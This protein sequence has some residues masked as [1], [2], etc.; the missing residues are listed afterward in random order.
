MFCTRATTRA[1]AVLGGV[2]SG[3][4]MTCGQYTLSAYKFADVHRA[5]FAMVLESSMDDV[6]CFAEN[7]MAFIRYARSILMHSVLPIMVFGC[8]GVF[9]SLN[10]YFIILLYESQYL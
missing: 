5:V 3:V 9:F 6:K 7:N 2:M 4:S 8:F 10:T 1:V